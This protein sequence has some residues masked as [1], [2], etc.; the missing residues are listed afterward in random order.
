MLV[1]YQGPSGTRPGTDGYFDTGDVAVVHESGQL[2]ITARK[3]SFVNVGG[4]K[5]NPDRVEERAADHPWV[6]EAKAF[7]RPGPGG[8]E[9]HLAVVLVGAGPAD[10]A[11]LTDF[12]RGGLA[13]Y[14]VPRHLHVLDR[15]PRTALGKVS[16]ADLVTRIEQT[17]SDPR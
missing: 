2:C 3:D 10:T 17:A 15:L 4:R 8:Q 6:R 12:L 9:L 1:G 16:I 14:E 13:P 5:V 7:G 11:T